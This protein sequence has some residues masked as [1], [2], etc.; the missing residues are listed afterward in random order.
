VRAVQ[1]PRTFVFIMLKI[2]S[3]AWRLHSVSDSALWE[4][5]DNAVGLLERRGR[6]V[7][8]LRALYKDAV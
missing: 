3:A 1:S 6:V 8:A 4:R 2:N 5:F 7:G